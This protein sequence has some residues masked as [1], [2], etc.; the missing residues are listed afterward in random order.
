[1]VLRH[2][3]ARPRSGRSTSAWTA[4]AASSAQWKRL[5]PM[6]M[7]SPKHQSHFTARRLRST[8]MLATKAPIIALRWRP[9]GS[10][11]KWPCVREASRTTRYARGENG[12]PDRVGQGSHPRQDGAPIPG[13]QAVVR[14]PEDP[15]EGNTHE[16]LQSEC[17]GSALELVHGSSHVA[18]QH[19]IGGS[20]GSWRPK[21][22]HMARV[23]LL[24]R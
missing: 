9:E 1:M 10:G 19:V 21:P 24:K 12:Q 23:L 15:T 18:M 13:D 22:P 2:V 7:A 4:R 20:V 3:A 11:S 16:P 8:Q 6:F 17:A 14:L 5:R